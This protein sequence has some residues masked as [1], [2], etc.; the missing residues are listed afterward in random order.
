MRPMC[1]AVPIIR[2]P[3]SWRN[4]GPPDPV[5]SSARRT[6]LACGVRERSSRPLQSR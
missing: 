1:F 5:S 2:P 3:R 4:D 6:F